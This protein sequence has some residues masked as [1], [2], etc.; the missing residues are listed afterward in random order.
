MYYARVR[1]YNKRVRRAYDR[2]N[3]RT[4]RYLRDAELPLDEISFGLQKKK[5]CGVIHKSEVLVI[6]NR[7]RKKYEIYRSKINKSTLTD[8]RISDT[9]DT[10]CLQKRYTLSVHAVYPPLPSGRATDRNRAA[11]RR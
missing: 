1:R 7:V 4:V 8:R 3:N 6:N 2:R 9:R 5:K 10:E 11:R